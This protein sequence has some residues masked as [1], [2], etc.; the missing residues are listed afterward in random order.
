M[1]HTDPHAALRTLLAR[2][3]NAGTVLA[4]AVLFAGVVMMLVKPGAPVDLAHFEAR[5]RRTDSVA[6]IGRDLL[7]LEPR[8][9][10]MAGVL[11]LLLI[12]AARTLAAGAVFAKE[13]DRLFVTIAAVVAGVL[14]FE[15][16]Y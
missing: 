2:L 5:A 6:S 12:P 13:R 7:S 3:L 11:I 10:V 8:A 14:V 16:F 4:G 9:V 1:K 15:I